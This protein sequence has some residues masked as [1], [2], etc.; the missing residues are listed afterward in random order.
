MDI[1]STIVNNYFVVESLQ[2]YQC[3]K[4]EFICLTIFDCR[5]ALFI[6]SVLDSRPFHAV[7][8]SN[9]AKKIQVPQI[10]RIGDA[11]LVEDYGT[12]PG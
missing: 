1:Y 4:D 12:K 9:S 8:E 7:D 3:T 5:K 6:S 2:N 10:P 11:L